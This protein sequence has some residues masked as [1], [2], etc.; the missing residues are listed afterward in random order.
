LL[1]ASLAAA[2]LTVFFFCPRFGYWKALRVP[3]AYFY[4]DVDRAV[5]V[6]QQIRDP[7]GPVINPSNWV[8]AWRLLLPLI[9]NY[10]HLPIWLLMIVPHIGCLVTIALTIALI[11]HYSGDILRSSMV[12]VTL[13]AAPWFFVSTGW[14]TYCDSWI[15]C[16]TLAA[17]FLPSRVILA[18]VC[19]LLPWI[20]ERILLA[21]PL[22]LALRAV[23]LQSTQSPPA[24]RIAVDAAIVAASYLLYAALRFALIRAGHG[25]QAVAYAQ[26][27]GTWAKI[28]ENGGWVYLSALWSALRAAWFFPAILFWL[29]YQRQ[30]LKLLTLIAAL[31][32]ATL[33]VS[34]AI[35]ADIGRGASMVAAPLAVA[36][37]A[38]LA[39]NK[40]RL[41]H[42]SIPWL[43]A[44]NL[45]LPGHIVVTVWTTPVRYF[46][47]E[48]DNSH[49][50]PVALD[51]KEYLYAGQKYQADGILDE[52]KD[53]FDC[54]IALDPDLTPALISRAWLELNVGQPGPAEADLR[55]AF[56]LKP[57]DPDALLARG[58]LNMKKGNL[59]AARADVQNAIAAAPA[60][61]PASQSA[62]S[63]MDQL[64][65]H[66]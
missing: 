53:N 61:W 57:N 58:L 25:G 36:G 55:H 7:F 32:L 5:S 51:P 38:M 6:L 26:N 47:A 22:C 4:P 34:L 28:T 43:M 30:N 40:P 13:A 24:R 33:A 41:F 29:L 63:L 15:I 19:V 2:L 23:N 60:N 46:Y 42:K 66:Q 37:T 56:E 49:S 50:P 65:Q 44:A 18:L 64:N 14:L 20:D 62:Q 59:A 16:G 11:H 9:W 48:L 3:P 52:A 17:S 1:L 27:Y 39:A 8:I 45:L 54:A 31:F 35:A 12:S 10:L 21:L